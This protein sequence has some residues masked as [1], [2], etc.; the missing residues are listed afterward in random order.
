MRTL[1]FTAILLSFL[2]LDASAA[3]KVENDGGTSDGGATQTATMTSKEQWACEVAMCLSNPGGMTEFA[4]CEAPIKKMLK[5]QAKGN[6]IPKC[7]FLSGGDGG[8]NTGG[9]SSD[10]ETPAEQQQQ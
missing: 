9:G 5:E 10:P 4:E 8:G 6:A 2:T 1:F 3:R 7:K